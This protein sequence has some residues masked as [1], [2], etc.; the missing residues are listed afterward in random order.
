[1]A[2]VALAGQTSGSV[3][4]AE[5]MSNLLLQVNSDDDMKD[6][7]INDALVAEDPRLGAQCKVR[8]R[9]RRPQRSRGL[10][11]RQR[12]GLGRVPGEY[13]DIDGNF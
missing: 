4:V 13:E 11:G 1:M 3:S 8:S 7:V 2:Y 6:D 9:Q 5:A 12:G 10:R